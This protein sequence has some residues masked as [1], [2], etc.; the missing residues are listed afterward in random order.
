MHK[1]MR[2]ELD[3]TVNYALGTTKPFLSAAELEDIRRR[4]TPTCMPGLPP[5]PIDSPGQAALVA[6][7]NPAQGNFLYF[8]TTDPTTGDTTFTASLKEATALRALAQKNAAAIAA[9][10]APALPRRSRR[11]Q[12]DRGRRGSRPSSAN[13]SVGRGLGSPVAHSLSP[14]LHRE[15]YRDSW[16]C[17]W[18][19][20]AIECDEAALPGVLEQ[21]DEV[22][23]RTLADD[24]AEARGAAAARRGE[25]SRCASGGCG[26][27]GDL[28]RGRPVPA[29][30]RREHRCLRHGQ[31]GASAPA[32]RRRQRRCSWRRRHRRRCARG[33]PAA[34]RTGTSRSLPCAI[35]ARTADVAAAA[36]RLGVDIKVVDWPGAT[37][38]APRRTGHRDR[39]RPGRPTIWPRAELPLL[40]SGQLLFDVLYHP[41]PTALA[42]AAEARRGRGHR[43]P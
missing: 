3:S 16:A 32:G 26:E 2:L 22:V 43:R 18:G 5:T 25:R 39:P 8:V 11:P 36:D 31:R 10:S 41:W 4:T 34:R 24:A 38:R 20:D 13:G 17:A 1:G 19:Y 30:P 6:A 27:H 14:V 23:R 35:A 21:L 37:R 40:A 12:N 42:A 15:A 29:A 28:R 33:G 7:L 9:G